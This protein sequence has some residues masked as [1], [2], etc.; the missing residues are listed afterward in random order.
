MTTTVSL[1]E[2]L[3][4]AAVQ[5]AEAD[6]MALEETIVFT[7]GSLVARL[8]VKA[9]ALPALVRV[10]PESVVFR[11]LTGGANA[12]E[13]VTFENR[14]GIEA[15]VSL[16]I[17]APFSVGESSFTLGPG[18][19]KEVVISLGAGS[20]AGAQGVL[21]VAVDSG[22]FEVPV[23]AIGAALPAIVP[24]P[25]RIPAAAPTRRREADS[26][27][28]VTPHSGPFAAAVE[29]VTG[30]S[31][32]F[33]WKDSAPAGAALRCLERV[34]TADE[35]GELASAFREYAA[36]KFVWRDGATVATVEKLEPGK[37]YLFR[38]DAVSGNGA[39]PVT[40][41]Q[42]RTPAPAKRE[43]FFSLV[44]V[45]LVLAAVAGGVSIWQR[46]RTRSGF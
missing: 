2:S 18:V 27:E 35:N 31:A 26:D 41:A 25:Q 46:T 42:L 37:A 30:N 40:F 9:E 19:E 45:L 44:N 33:R 7:A 6:A 17:G 36:C 20:A 16:A 11:K 43:S 3:S 12:K 14:G 13:R 4:H 23:E 28:A 39:T 29:S 22:G 32:T 8:P 21:R 10:R 24:A 1:G 15:K 38:I 34:L 5:T